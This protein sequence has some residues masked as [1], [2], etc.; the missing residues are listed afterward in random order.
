MAKFAA[1]TLNANVQVWCDIDGVSDYHTFEAGTAEQDLPAG[2]AEQ[3]GAH[4]WSDA[5]VVDARIAT[6]NDRLN[7]YGTPADMVAELAAFIGGLSKRRPS[8]ADET[9]SEYEAGVREVI[10]RTADPDRLQSA[11]VG[12]KQIHEVHAGET[13][14]QYRERALAVYGEPIDWRQWIGQADAGPVEVTAGEPPVEV[15]HDWDA[16]SPAPVPGSESAAVPP[17]GAG[18]NS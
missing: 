6:I 9:I 3:I 10:A 2:V 17:A 1:R 14:E 11:I 16:E 4:A 12:W 15:D 5:P 18:T 7:A 8:E 13:Y